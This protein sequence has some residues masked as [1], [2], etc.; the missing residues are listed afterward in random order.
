MCVIVEKK[1]LRNVW[2]DWCMK[3]SSAL[4]FDNMFQCIGYDYTTCMDYMDPD[5]HCPQKGC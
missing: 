3:D 5:V 1:Y 2:I 4:I